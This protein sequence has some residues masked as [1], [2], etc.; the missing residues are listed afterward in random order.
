MRKALM[1]SA[2]SLVLGATTAQ[3]KK[4]GPSYTFGTVSGGDFCDGITNIVVNDDYLT[5]VH[6]YTGCGYPSTVT[7]LLGGFGGHVKAL[8]PG[9]WYSLLA[10]NS[11]YGSPYF[12]LEYYVNFPDSRFDAAYESAEYGYPFYLYITNGTLIK[13]YADAKAPPSMI[14]STVTAALKSAKLL[15]K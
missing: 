2:M 11:S 9:K 6:N 10:S 7:G 15:R 8:G 4:I 5:G 1:L 12:N 3:A 14:G 13:G